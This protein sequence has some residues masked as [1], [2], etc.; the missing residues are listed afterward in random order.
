MFVA[1]VYCDYNTT[2]S[3]GLVSAS[4][5]PLEFQEPTNKITLNVIKYRK[6]VITNN[7]N[8]C[9]YDQFL[10]SCHFWHHEALAY[11]NTTQ[12]G[13][14]RFVCLQICCFFPTFVGRSFKRIIIHIS[15]V[16]RHTS[17][18]NIYYAEHTIGVERNY[19]K[20]KILSAVT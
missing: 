2:M 5:W 12:H 10:I 13:R 7:D 15:L 8:L 19:S 18:T 1:Q 11:R 20:N 16:A 4:I 3:D 6:F 14:A 17:H 9:S